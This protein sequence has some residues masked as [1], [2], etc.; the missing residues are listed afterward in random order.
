MGNDD[1]GGGVLGGLWGLITGKGT[2]KVLG[3][4]EWMAEIGKYFGL[5]PKIANGIY[6]L[7]SIQKAFS[8]EIDKKETVARVVGAGVNWLT[9]EKL[10]EMG[11]PAPLAAALG[12]VVSHFLTKFIRGLENS[13]IKPSDN[14]GDARQ[15]MED[16]DSAR[17]KSGAQGTGVDASDG[18]TS[19]PKT[20][21]ILSDLANAFTGR[22]FSSN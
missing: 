22:N 18:G 20:P 10:E 19:P 6:A 8:G 9:T 16:V 12:D 21:S 3:G 15:R 2:S 17:R 11:L 5:D 4:V 14:A 7:E 1:S 13:L